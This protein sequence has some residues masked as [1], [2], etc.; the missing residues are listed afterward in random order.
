MRAVETREVMNWR[1]ESGTDIWKGVGV[2]IAIIA[3]GRG[4]RFPRGSRFYQLRTED[5]K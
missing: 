1:R 5:G 4:L 3:T 2:G